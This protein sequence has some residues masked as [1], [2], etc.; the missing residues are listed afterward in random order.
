MVGLQ[1]SCFYYCVFMF[2]G[3][4]CRREDQVRVDLLCAFLMYVQYNTPFDFLSKSLFLS[5]VF[6]PL[7]YFG[8]YVFSV[9]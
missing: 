4:L 7:V 6:A 2:L 3:V 9:C 1:I 5:L 8:G